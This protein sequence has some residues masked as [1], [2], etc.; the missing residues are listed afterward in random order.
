MRASAN[1]LDPL[2]FS[3]FYIS[4]F[5]HVQRDFVW[6]A[7]NAQFGGQIL[8]RLTAAPPFRTLPSMLPGKSRWPAVN[9]LR[10]HSA[11]RHG[12]VW[13]WGNRMV[14]S[15]GWAG[16]R[17]FGLTRAIRGSEDGLI[18]RYSVMFGSRVRQVV[19]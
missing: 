12:V 1:A 17:A 8:H 11:V 6:Q 5:A 14:V 9:A 18:H 15:V 10:D 19:Q 16:R 2:H 13:H 4:I 3:H 7:E